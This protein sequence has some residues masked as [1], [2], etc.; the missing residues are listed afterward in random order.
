MLKKHRRWVRRRFQHTILL[1]LVFALLICDTAACLASRLAGSLAFS[2]TAVLCALAEVLCF[3]CL[4]TL[5]SSFLLENF[6]S[7]YYITYFLLSQSV[8]CKFIFLLHLKCK[9]GKI[10][11]KCNIYSIFNNSDLIKCIIIL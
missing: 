11:Q 7:M 6:Y 10:F 9:P 2:A 8:E 4:D 5:H 1:L 3:K